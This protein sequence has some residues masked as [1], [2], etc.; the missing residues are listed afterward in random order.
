[1]DILKVV[2]FLKAVVLPMIDRKCYMG[3]HGHNAFKPY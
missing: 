1:M 2:C 3:C